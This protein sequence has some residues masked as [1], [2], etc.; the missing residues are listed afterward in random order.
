MKINYI[1]NVRIPTTRAQGYAIMK[2]CSEFASLGNEVNL[3]VP[4]RINADNIKENIF[5][6]YKVKNN[7]NIIKVKSFDLLANSTNFG[8]LYYWIDILSFLINSKLK[9][10]WNKNDFL[11]T[12]DFIVPLF[13]YKNKNIIL[14]VHDVPTSKFLLNKIIK[15]PRLFVV[16]SNGLKDELTSLGVPENRICVSPSGIDSS[17]FNVSLDKYEARKIIG[18]P[19]NEKLVFYIGLLDEWKGYRTLLEVSKKQNI[20]FKI[21]IIGGES[22]QIDL[23]KIEYPNVIFLGFKP[24]TELAINQITADVLV[25]PNSGKYPISKKYTSPLKVFNHMMSGVPIIA[26]DLP[27]IREIL[28][29]SNCFFAESDNPDSF[30]TTINKVL[31][32]PEEVKIAV[33]NAKKDVIKYEW[34]SRAEK[35]L[36]FINKNEL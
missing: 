31:S 12:R 16:I 25:V 2:M 14:E 20:G 7:F 34:S 19:L 5:D 17:D 3:F 11:Y 33:S 27:S 10:S 24:Y 23:L 29:E 15:I 6:F 21:V 8:R 9:I 28:N 32:S 18:L 30:L 13:F 26:S 4:N 22:H 1:T 36:K 35:I